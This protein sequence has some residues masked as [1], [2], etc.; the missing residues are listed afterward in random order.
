MSQED[1]QPR[2]AIRTQIAEGLRWLY[3]HRLLR[4]SPSSSASSPSANQM[5]QAVLV[6][7]A[8]PRRCTSG[9]AGTGCCWRSRPSAA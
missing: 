8:S 3:R 1:G 2:A 4:V 6:L 7:L 9:P 5:G